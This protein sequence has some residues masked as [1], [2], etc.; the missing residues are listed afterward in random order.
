MSL[1]SPIISGGISPFIG[2]NIEI[3]PTS[4]TYVVNEPVL[5][6][7]VVTVRVFAVGGLRKRERFLFGETEFF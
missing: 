4:V 2:S 5:R 6:F 7:S 1:I 3:P